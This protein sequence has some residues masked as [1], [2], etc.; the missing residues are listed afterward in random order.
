M[1]SLIVV[2]IIFGIGAIWEIEKIRKDTTQMRL[3]MEHEGV[4]WREA[5]REIVAISRMMEKEIHDQTDRRLRRE[6]G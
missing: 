2:V 5:C 1:S 3:M 4:A 6:L